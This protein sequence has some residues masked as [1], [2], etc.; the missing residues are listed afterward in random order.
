MH[1]GTNSFHI[2][3]LILGKLVCV[4][5][6]FQGNVPYERQRGAIVVPPVAVGGRHHAGVSS[7]MTGGLVWNGTLGIIQADP[8]IQVLSD[9]KG[10]KFCYFNKHSEQEIPSMYRGNIH[11]T[12]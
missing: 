12:F 6:G 5:R 10:G 2:N 11:T 4:N 9:K 7:H 3:S 8:R 1:P